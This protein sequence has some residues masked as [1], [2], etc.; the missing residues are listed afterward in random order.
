MAASTFAPDTPEDRCAKKGAWA[1]SEN[2]RRRLQFLDDAWPVM[3][4]GVGDTMGPTGTVNSQ[5]NPRQSQIFPR[6]SPDIPGHPQTSP[7]IPKHP[8]T[9]PD[10]L[11]LYGVIWGYSLG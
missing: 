1:S 11:G 6:Y 9:S 8:Q 3:G 2:L 5:R 7:N 10:Y 4:T